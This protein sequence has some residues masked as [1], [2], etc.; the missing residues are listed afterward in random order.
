MLTFGRSECGF[1]TCTSHLLS[2]V[3]VVIPGKLEP[4]YKL[5]RVD[6]HDCVPPPKRFASPNLSTHIIPFQSCC[7]LQSCS[8][9]TGRCGHAHQSRIA[10]FLIS[11]ACSAID[12]PSNVGSLVPMCTLMH[13]RTPC[14]AGTLP[15]KLILALGPAAGLGESAGGWIV[16]EWACVWFKSGDGMSTRFWGMM[17]QPMPS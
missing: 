9:C 4:T 15:L 8:S 14:F 10:S 3:S 7:R 1:W 17:Q 11:V 16:P 6:P 12:F 5:R 2:S 13:L